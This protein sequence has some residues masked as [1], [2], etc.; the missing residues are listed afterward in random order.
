MFD[1]EQKNYK[2]SDIMDQITKS[3]NSS[4]PMAVWIEAE[5]TSITKQS[6]SG[7]YYLDI[8]ESDA[9]GNE[10]CK[11]KASIWKTKAPAIVDK[12]KKNTG[13]DLKSGL[14][15]LIKCRVSFHQ[16]YQL[17]LSVEDINP[18][19]TLGG[20]E[21]KIKEIMDKLEKEGITYKNKALK[22][23]FDF[24]KL[25]VVA[26]SGAAGL[27]DFKKDADILEKYN[28]CSFDYY[29]ATFQ[30]NDT[31]VSVTKA[32]NLALQNAND[33][34][35]LIVIR[36]GGAKTDLHY[37]NEY[38]IAAAICMA[39][40]P[41]F[42]GVGHERDKGV[43]DYVANVSFDTPSKVIGHIFSVAV[44][45]ATLIKNYFKNIEHGAVN[46]VTKN[47]LEVNNTFEMIQVHSQKNVQIFKE[48]TNVLYQNIKQDAKNNITIFEKDANN[49]Y[50][51][52]LV[53]SKNTINNIEKTVID[54]IKYV[55][56]QGQSLVTMHKKDIENLDKI[57]SGYNPEYI[58]NIG[59]LL[60]KKQGKIV[61][62]TKDL[63]VGDELDLTFKD[64]SITVKIIGDEK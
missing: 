17:S 14:K 5:I 31:R 58:L 25:A 59:F 54:K 28:V 42:V 63:T 39:K 41:V 40:I 37:L 20:I 55:L 62:S 2:L 57:I 6:S 3:V 50:R 38:D 27:G 35:A 43:L 48:R 18:E 23:P 8:M 13:T 36:G 10:V 49:A 61:S 33:Y 30:G 12:F 56:N 9:K 44:N 52:S 32:I 34:D 22:A 45:N 29:E 64:G 15:V 16:K 53:F 51:N 26:P 7:H 46:F 24:Y 21:V 11:T 1:T 60:A 19:F 4:F 47:K